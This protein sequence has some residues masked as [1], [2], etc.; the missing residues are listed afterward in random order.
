[1]APALVRHLRKEADTAA[2]IGGPASARHASCL[3]DLAERI[4]GL[5]PLADQR[6]FCVWKAA[7]SPVSSQWEPGP[8]VR[9]LLGRAGVGS[10]APPADEILDELVSASPE[11][12]LDGK[13][14]ELQEA[15]RELKRRPEGEQLAEAEERAE[16]EGMRAAQR[17]AD[18][19]EAREQLADAEKRLVHLKAVLDL[20]ADTEAEAPSAEAPIDLDSA[21]SAGKKSKPR[22]E[23]VS[24]YRRTACGAPTPLC[25]RLSATTPSTSPN[26][27]ATRTPA[28]PSGPTSGPSSGAIG[29]R[30][31]IVKPS[32]GHLIGQQWAETRSRETRRPRS[33]TG[34]EG[35][36]TA[37][38]SHNQAPTGR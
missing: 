27:S 14:A 6:L 5:H 35:S 8:R 18:L 16:R 2:S 36:E 20:G 31:R 19:E 9:E 21:K 29:S 33:T 10:A 23:R 22:R 30:A 3:R 28:S 1:M 24:G 4:A 7:G 26:S 17:T 38:P 37:L 13:A 25:G 15:R 32:M 12:G 34:A 11:D